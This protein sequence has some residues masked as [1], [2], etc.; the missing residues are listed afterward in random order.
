MTDVP[1]TGP[2]ADEPAEP[3]A[4]VI[5]VGIGPAGSSGPDVPPSIALPAAEQPVL[6][7]CTVATKAQL[8]AVRTLGAAFLTVHNNGRF[9]A[10]IV[11]ADPATTGQGVLAP[12]DIGIGDRELAELA[13][14][15][16]AEQ[17]C[18]VLRPRLLERLLADRGPVL[19]LDPSVHVVDSVADHVVPALARKPLVLVPRVLRPLSDDGMRPT[20]EELAAA[21]VY[22]SGFVAVAPGAEAFLHS[23]FDTVRQ[24]PEA[25]ATFLDSAPA[26]VDHE[27]LRDP[28]I[29]LSV[30]S[31]GQRQLTKDDD[32]ALLIDGRP[33]RTVHF[34][35][36]DPQRPW[37]LSADVTARPRVLLSEHTLLAELC[38]SY[39][40]ELVR[41]GLGQER[42]EY[43][44]GQLAD[45][46]SLP[47]GLRAE[48]RRALLAADRAGE[49]PPAPAFGTAQAEFIEWAAEPVDGLPGS[50]R[51]A[52]AVWQDD[53]ALRGQFAEPFGADSQAF[54]EWCAG[55]GVASGRIHLDAV[56]KRP[57]GETTLL[58]QL[59]VSVLGSGWVA[60]LVAAS[61]RSSG[62][63]A[64]TEPGYP[65]VLLCDDEAS[66]PAE[67]Y[68][69][70]VR[71]GP[72]PVGGPA[73]VNEVWVTSETTRAALEQTV[74]V[75]VRAITLPVL[76][77]PAREEAARAASRSAHNIGDEVV[78]ATVVDH[79][80]ERVGNALGSVSAFLAA[81]PDRQDVLLLLAV[82]GS[83]EHPE[84][85][86][87]LRLAT[88]TD[89]RIRLVEDPIS[90]PFLLDAADWALSLHRG[91]GSDLLAWGLTEAAARGVPVI[92]SAH[93]VVTELF[94]EDTAV[95]V[96]CH[97]GGT[98]PDIE[99]A[100]KLLREV[101][102]DPEVADRL[103][104]TGR[105]HLLR[106][107]SLPKVADQLKE[108]VEHAYR[109]WRA[110]RSA[111]RSGN[112]TDPL[113]P[114]HSAKHAL[115]RQPDVDVASRMPMAPALRKGVLR[116][117]NHY[118]NH[119][120]D[121]LGTVLDGM[122]R[123]AGELL[124]RQDEIREVG[125]LVELES[126]R[127]DFER[128]I[129]RHSQLGDQLVSTDDGV[130]RVS[131]DLAGQGRRLRELEDALVGEA[132]K[133]TKQLDT[134][135][136]RLDRLTLMLDKTLDRI[137]ALES[138]VAESLR[139]RDGRLE[140]GLRAADQAL[141][142]SDALRRVVV[143]E[144]ERHGGTV[145]GV[146]SSLVLC[147]VG[148][149]RLP[150]E[151]AL[152]LP[153]LSSNGVW[154][155]ELSGLID[156]LVE[157]D[158]VFV[159]IGAHVG[160][161]T[162]RVLSL[163]GA[164]GA[165]VAVEPCDSVRRLLRHN[166]SVNLSPQI[167]ERLVVVEGAAWDQA[168]DLLAEPTLTG[169]VAVRPNPGPPVHAAASPAQNQLPA[170]SVQFANAPVLE[171][172][173]ENKPAE[174][175][176]SVRGVRLDKELESIPSLSGMRLS[177]VKVDA[178]GR[179]HR[180]LGGLVRLLRRDRP[181]VLCAFSPSAI[182]DLGDDPITVLREFRTWGY[183]LVPVDQQ[184]IASPEEVLEA[185]GD[186]R[187]STLWLRPRGKGV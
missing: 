22:D 179:E 34:N 63:P 158:G 82:S 180:A 39:R 127:A 163:L 182:T 125:G 83:A 14:A 65:V 11:D 77:R 128:L 17:L 53:P 101:A 175:G 118:D 35:G 99:V 162:I 95:L 48:Y 117:L 57:G 29:G 55:P 116:V 111:S 110:R 18:A 8:P 84:A 109:T 6:S 154:E 160:Y 136:D 104:R 96:P 41:H 146:S 12:A 64:A 122:E 89:P 70:A 92:A 129:D 130:V 135:A 126:L 23:W 3:I 119:L 9:V 97:H 173:D 181:H 137:D 148:L 168:T 153:L 102:D 124:R 71:T 142:T 156:S 45:G 61:A 171:P 31:A 40:N 28:G 73:D 185:T 81:F 133:R 121:V 36:F 169:G 167:A 93:G 5:K 68:V 161:H 32:A 10:L 100:S 98:E 86:E 91:G 115:L 69:V 151:D 56:P 80:A 58:E 51:W 103:S 38:T 176:G 27:V 107:Y 123:T 72:G 131:A 67:R 152:M 7:A 2:H 43:G 178:P 90:L 21:G 74:S 134:L 94:D 150:S 30:W 75:P 44:F 143:R 139:E 1:A 85:A 88:A 140:S 46:T 149:L 106:A 144:H 157:P 105:W 26:L 15:C 52:L 147:D 108:R 42:A 37:L 25:A 59:G 62:L 50:T 183:D 174:L 141:H 112:D 184:R 165:V 166:V 159:D 186:S 172:M 87:R 145:E 114:L 49:R 19:Y 66:A 187:S 24:A 113:G 76:D 78:F 170:G 138:K 13:T 54:R 33:L 20:P 132:A 164:S 16:T 155:P 79:A 4:S 177:V 120:R 47:T 60:D